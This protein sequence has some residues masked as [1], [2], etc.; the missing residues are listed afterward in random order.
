MLKRCL[1]IRPDIEFEFSLFA[2][3]AEMDQKGRNEMHF[4]AGFEKKVL[5]VLTGVLA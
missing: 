1:L 4:V 2:T 3:R 5:N